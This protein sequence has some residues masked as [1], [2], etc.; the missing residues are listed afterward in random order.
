MEAETTEW[1]T[2]ALSENDEFTLDFSIDIAEDVAAQVE[3]MLRKSMLGYFRQA[4]EVFEE[5]LVK[6]TDIFPVAVE[7]MR[8]LHGQGDFGALLQSVVIYERDHMSSPLHNDIPDDVRS[9]II[10]LLKHIALLATEKTPSGAPRLTMVEFSETMKRFLGEPSK[11]AQPEQ[12]S[13]CQMASVLY[14]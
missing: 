9:Q 1:N 2:A 7:R 11:E 10:W 5:R 13:S 14:S 3:E 12:V 6:H 4:R 8:L